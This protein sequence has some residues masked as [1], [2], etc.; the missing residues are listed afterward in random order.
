M[1]RWAL[2]SGLV[3]VT[4]IVLCVLFRCKP[5][6]T[7]TV[8]IGT[9]FYHMAIR[10]LIGYAFD[11]LVNNRTNF[12]K[13]WYQVTRWETVLYEKI[14]VRQW[15]K[16]IPTYDAALFDPTRHSWTDIA[17]AMC[18]AE[19]IHEVNMAASFIPLAFS[20][21]F[22]ALPVFVTTSILAAACDLIFV[23][24]QRYN[25]PRILRLAHRKA[26]VR[27]SADHTV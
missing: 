18:Q 4:G 6:L 5:L 15:K 3:T 16:K 9:T 10:L 14:R 2:C 20:I 7:L 13:R 12:E 1:K 23:I 21:W 11:Q 24:L 26:Q 25:R 22:G 27:M 8:A 17:R 19:L